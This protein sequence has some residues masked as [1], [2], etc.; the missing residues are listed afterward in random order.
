MHLFSFRPQACLDLSAQSI[1]KDPSEPQ[2]PE[3]APP[4]T[5]SGKAISVQPHAAGASAR[6]AVGREWV[7]MG[8]SDCRLSVLLFRYERY[9]PHIHK[10][11]C[12][13]V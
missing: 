10:Y 12:L 4:N 1:R 9:I 5:A 8:L 2:A 7:K 3:A 13:V 6:R 11:T